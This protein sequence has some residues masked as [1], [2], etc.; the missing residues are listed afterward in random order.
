MIEN[1]GV[2]QQIL[3]YLL[4][5]DILLVSHNHYDHLDD[6]TVRSLANKDRIF[7]VIP[8]GLKA[9]FIERGYKNITELDWGESIS[10]DNIKLTALPAVYDSA[11]SICP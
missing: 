4:L 9:F 7:V 6:K 1:F 10:I 2:F 8:L 3:L 5:I 11:R